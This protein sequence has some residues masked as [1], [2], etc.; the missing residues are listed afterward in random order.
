MT[1]IKTSI[2]LIAFC[3]ICNNGF[4]QH[5]VRSSLSSFGSSKHVDGLHIQSTVGQSSITTTERNS[6]H[7]LLLRQGFQQSILIETIVNNLNVNLF[8]NPNNGEFII[9]PSFGPVAYTYTV[10]DQFSREI[11][12]GLGMGNLDSTVT[13][14]NLS[15]GIYYV[16]ISDSFNKKIFK[17]VIQ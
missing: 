16:E 7:D 1:E 15:T 6:D 10:F 2:F 5:I 14:N 9:N 17:I 12:S 8:P 3:S 4:S 13:L 11:A